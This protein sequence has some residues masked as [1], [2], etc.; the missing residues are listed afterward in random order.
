MGRVKRY[1][2]IKSCDPFCPS[3]HSKA[4]NADDLHD[5]PPEPSDSERE[6]GGTYEFCLGTEAVD[7]TGYLGP[8]RTICV[9]L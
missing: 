9:F 6:D 3:G 1:K 5:L 8:P 4:G 2:K 7:L